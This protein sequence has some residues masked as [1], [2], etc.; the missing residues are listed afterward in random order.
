M[1]NL[2]APERTLRIILGIILLCTVALVL[3]GPLGW[4]GAIIGV[5]L[6]ATGITG[7]CPLFSLFGLSPRQ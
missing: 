6:I 5:I 7:I 3:H 1:P 4:L 2:N